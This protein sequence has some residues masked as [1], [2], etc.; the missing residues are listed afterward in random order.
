MVCDTG[1]IVRIDG[2]MYCLNPYSIGIWSATQMNVLLLYLTKNCLNP[3]S[4]GIW[5][6]T[7]KIKS[8][9]K[10]ISES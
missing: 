3:Y 8:L 6:A 4:I 9:N 7:D 5:S 1:D 10:L 2:K